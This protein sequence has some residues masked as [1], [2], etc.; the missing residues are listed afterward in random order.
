MAAAALKANS[1]IKECRWL[2][3][4][5]SATY[6]TTVSP[7]ELWRQGSR[8]V[9]TSFDADSPHLVAP[10]TCIG[11]APESHTCH[12]YI[13]G[14]GC[15]PT[16]NSSTTWWLSTTADRGCATIGLSYEWGPLSDLER[17]NVCRERVDGDNNGIQDM[18]SKYHSDIIYGGSE[19]GLVDVDRCN[20]I[21]GRLTALLRY[22]LK[23]RPEEERWENFLLSGVGGTRNSL[24]DDG[25]I[26]FNNFIFSGHS[27]GSGHV[28]YLAKHVRIARAI[29]ISGPQEYLEIEPEPLSD[30]RNEGVSHEDSR[31]QTG[32]SSSWLDG[33]YATQDIRAFMHYEEE[34]T[35]D[36]I[37]QNWSSIEPIS[38]YYNRN[39]A[40][41]E[42]KEH[43]L[44]A[45]I[46]S[47]CLIDDIAVIFDSSGNVASR[48]NSETLYHPSNLIDMSKKE[49]F[50][51]YCSKLVDN[52]GDSYR[53]FY[54]Q[55]VPSLSPLDP[56]GARPNH[57]STISDKS[58]PFKKYPSVS[59]PDNLLHVLN[60]NSSISEYIDVPIYY[61]SIWPH[62][63]E[64][65]TRDD[66]R[67]KNDDVIISKL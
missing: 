53:T 43:L 55:L 38:L 54:T 60:Q 63:L 59:L 17:N 2:K 18:L 11:S 23:T 33:I 22:L 47:S 16:E 1:R 65:I 8:G 10:F 57:V 66:D 40:N 34:F 6:A 15:N 5:P 28:C 41:I 32:S 7:P 29:L 20:S 48:N 3:I 27:Q 62:L 36:L 58:T 61:L 14:T 46:E 37:R 44:P 52:C 12:V 39:Y 42:S 24:S 56:C 30:N 21:V 49:E 45:T 35:A 31:A 64:S 13:C 67:R 19:S 4:R 25:E 50:D 51:F 26:S 9:L